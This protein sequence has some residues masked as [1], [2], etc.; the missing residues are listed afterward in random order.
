MRS[1]LIMTK[2][3]A[4]TVVESVEKHICTFDTSNFEGVKRMLNAKNSAVS[5]NSIGDKAI[6][7]VDVFTSD[8]VRARS[9]P[10]KHCVNAYLFDSEG[11]AYFTQSEGIVRS[12]RDIIA[13]LPDLNK[14]N[15]GINIHVVSTVNANG[16]TLKSIEML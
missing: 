13:V 1:D 10:P 3:N 6:T 5:L 15:G 8:G 14:A 11:V 9:N 7:V 12:L 2:N 16:N 4:E